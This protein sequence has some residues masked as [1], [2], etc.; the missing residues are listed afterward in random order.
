MPVAP[1]QHVVHEALV[2]RHVDEADDL[3]A[4]PRPVGK[5][6]IDGDAARLLLLQAIGIDAGQLACTSEV[7]P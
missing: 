3:A 4:R 5:A 2:A 7:L 1:G 6:E